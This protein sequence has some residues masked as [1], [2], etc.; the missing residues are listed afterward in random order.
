MPASVQGFGLVGRAAV[1]MT[2][3]EGF[4]VEQLGAAACSQDR[5]QYAG[6]WGFE[7]VGPRFEA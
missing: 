5:L 4:K 6:L 3:S 7:G 1:G 2:C